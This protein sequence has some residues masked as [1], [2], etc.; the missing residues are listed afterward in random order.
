MHNKVGAA[1]VIFQDSQEIHKERTRLNNDTT[2]FQAEV[3]AL[4]SALLWAG[5][6]AS[7]S[8]R[9]A[10]FTD[11]L[12]PL[13]SLNSG[14]ISKRSIQSLREII[15]TL[16][17]THKVSLN[18][19]KAHQGTLGNERADEEAK[20]ATDK[21]VVDVHVPLSEKVAKNRLHK[22]A[23]IQW[24]E[25]WDEG[26]TGRMTYKIFPKVS[27]TR[28]KSNDYENQALSNHGNF[29]SY[30]VRF[31]KKKVRCACGTSGSIADA[32][33]YIK[34]CPL[35]AP[36]R[37]RLFPPS[38]SSLETEHLEKYPIEIKGIRE[39]IKKVTDQDTHHHFI[40]FL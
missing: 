3:H 38:L 20:K 30:I 35:T 4:R 28:L 23:L 13:H 39:I 29:P 22:E 17:S 25:R 33:H 36:D 12:S 2:V 1:W 31:H 32:A 10:F 15:N 14:K 34:T 6:N 24:Q 26:T 7:S 5:Q 11:S 40:E 21:E 19:V 16:I 37:K 9:V 8:T 27:T 18:W